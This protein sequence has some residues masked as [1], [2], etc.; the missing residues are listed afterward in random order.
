[1]FPKTEVAQSGET[2]PFHVYRGMCESFRGALAAGQRKDCL[3]SSMLVVDATLWI[4]GGYKILRTQKST[5]V[6]DCP[7]MVGWEDCAHGTPLQ[8]MQIQGFR[9]YQPS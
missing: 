5:C 3:D 8:L 7:E 9:C 6:L 4:L 2:P 1:M